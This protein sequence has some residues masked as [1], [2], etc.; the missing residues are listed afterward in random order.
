MAPAALAERGIRIENS[1]MQNRIERK[2]EE[3]PQPK[4]TGAGPTRLLQNG[5]LVESGQAFH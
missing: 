5:A 4:I 1:R 2:E 3:Q